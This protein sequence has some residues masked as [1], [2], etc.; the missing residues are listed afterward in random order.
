MGYKVKTLHTDQF[1]QTCRDLRKAVEASGYRPD[2]I[3]AIPRAGLWMQEAA[4]SD[5]PVNSVRLVRP[6]KGTLKRNISQIIKLLP[7]KLRDNI[8]IWEARKLVKRSRHMDNTGIILPSLSAGV[9]NILL[10]DDAVD[11]GAT[12]KAIVEKFK[13]EYP[14]ADIRSAVITKTYPDAIFDPDYCIYNDSILIRTPWSIDM[15]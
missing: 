1:N 6:P 8:R 5:Y 9:K 4:W 3:V 15:K 12:L 13:A 7:L 14:D 2:A 11:S 10:I